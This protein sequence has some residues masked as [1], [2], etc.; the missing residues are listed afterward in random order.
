MNT[1]AYKGYICEYASKNGYCTIPR[2]KKFHLSLEEFIYTYC[3]NCGS[4]RCTGPQTQW[5]DGCRMKNRLRKE[6]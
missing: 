5:F 3:H 4:Q 1:C 6:R 2:C